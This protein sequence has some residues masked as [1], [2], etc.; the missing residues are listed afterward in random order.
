[1][2]SY[3]RF[4]L[5]E[6]RRRCPGHITDALLALAARPNMFAVELLQRRTGVALIPSGPIVHAVFPDR[7]AEWRGTTLE[8][9]HQLPNTLLASIEGRR[10]DE[11]VDVEAGGHLIIREARTGAGA[12][13]MICADQLAPPPETNAWS[14]TGARLLIAWRVSIAYLAITLPNIGRTLSEPS[15]HTATILGMLAMSAIIGVMMIMSVSTGVEKAFYAAFV[16]TTLGLAAFWPP[17]G[18]RSDMARR[19]SGR[20]L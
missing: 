20:G 8:I 5:N 6:V 12:T 1:M 17:I 7:G 18:W 10:V 13:R 16:L 9:P 2:A 15:P 11:V 3:E 19:L 4:A 14:L